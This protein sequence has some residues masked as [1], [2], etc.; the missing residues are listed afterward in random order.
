MKPTLEGAQLKI[1]QR[2]RNV[3]QEKSFSSLTTTALATACGVTRRN[4]YHHFSS[5]EAL[6]RAAMVM[7]NQEAQ[8][9]ANWAAQKAMAAHH[10]ALD[11]I[12]EWLDVRFGVTRRN[13]ARSPHGA[14]LNETA[15]RI[16]SDIMIEVSHETNARIAQLID[17]LQRRGALKLRDGVSPPDAAQL[18]ADGA[19]GVNQ[20]RPP[21][22]PSQL[23]KRYRAITEAILFGC[24]T[25]G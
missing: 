17:E 11:V 21:I 22:P 7:G 14:E 9:R 8:E 6:F 15:F 4:F 5:K 23:G 25:G 2:A 19:R 18:I 10:N 1:V 16:G 20:E 12:S 24:A 3:F 13:V